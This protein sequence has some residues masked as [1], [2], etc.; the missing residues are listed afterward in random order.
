MSTKTYYALRLMKQCISPSLFCK[1]AKPHMCKHI[2]CAIPTVVLQVLSQPSTWLILTIPHFKHHCSLQWARGILARDDCSFAQSLVSRDKPWNNI[3]LERKAPFFFTEH[4]PAQTFSGTFLGWE[5]V[6][7][8][9]E[10]CTSKPSFQIY[11]NVC[12]CCIWLW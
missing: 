6:G 2:P 9:Y 3:H 8:A 5:E 12:V 7:V 11:G 10:I 4:L 1:T